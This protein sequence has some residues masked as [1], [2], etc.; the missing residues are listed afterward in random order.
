MKAPNI[1]KVTLAPK[2]RKGW[3]L[4]VLKVEKVE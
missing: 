2:E 1:R 4:A 3:T